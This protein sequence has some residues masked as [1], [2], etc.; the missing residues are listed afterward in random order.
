MLAMSHLW[1]VPADDM[2][3]VATKG[4]PEAILDLCHADQ[5]TCARVLADAS[6]LAAE[7]CR[8]LGVA[9]ARHPGAVWPAGQHD[10]NFEFLGLIALSDPIR[11]EVPAAIAQCRAAGIRV[12]MMT[13]DYPTTAQAIGAQIGLEDGR[14]M[15]GAALEEMSDSALQQC[16]RQ[17]P[18]FARVLPKHK[19]RLVQALQ[20]AGE[21]V[22]MTGDGVNDAPALKAAHIGVAMGK[23]GTDVARESAD[24]VLLE[25]NFSAIVHA[26]RLGRRI[27]ANLRKAMVYT[28]AV[29]L[30]IVGMSL[31]PL[32]LGLPLM[33]A[34]AHILFLELVIDPTC[35]IVFEDEAEE[36]GLMRRPPRRQDE[37]LLDRRHIMLSLLQGGLATILVATLYIVVLELGCAE[38]AARA[39]GFVALVACGVSLVITNRT[40]QPHRHFSLRGNG[41]FAWVVLVTFGCLALI[42]SFP[43]LRE[44]FR[45]APLAWQGWAGAL[46]TGALG[47]PL[48]ELAKKHCLA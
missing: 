24:L 47:L 33:L 11:P 43:A 3:R 12:V 44:L 22:A 39:C 1:R 45:F 9:R 14:I 46:F 27:F 21:V 19:L 37:S 8:V 17:V 13:G 18:I 29:H 38:G 16:I 34:P 36:A 7:G 40:H 35:S 5:A 2:H 41:T 4:A 15:T 20:A 48:F 10:F 25:D 30:P 28:I 31:L 23:R 26:V 32:L 6:R 42:F